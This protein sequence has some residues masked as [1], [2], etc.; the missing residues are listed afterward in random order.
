MILLDIREDIWSITI[1][2]TLHSW[3]GRS[4]VATKFPVIL[5]V[6]DVELLHGSIWW[7]V[8]VTAVFSQEQEVSEKGKSFL[9]HFVNFFNFSITVDI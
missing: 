4:C 9:K 1:V 3:W 8:C 5:M 2:L 7:L 6:K